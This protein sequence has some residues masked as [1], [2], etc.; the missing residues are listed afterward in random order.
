MG[1]SVEPRPKKVDCTFRLSPIFGVAH[2]VKVPSYIT[3]CPHRNQVSHEM[4]CQVSSKTTLSCWRQLGNYLFGAGNDSHFGD[5]LKALRETTSW[6]AFI[7]FLIPCLC[8]LQT[9]RRF[10]GPPQI[11]LSQTFSS[12]WRVVESLINK[13]P[14]IIHL[15]IS[16]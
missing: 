13:D 8:K 12:F 3:K 10:R 1:S 11:R 6:M 15:N 9:I 4:P 5:S 7:P 2:G 14:Y 16:L